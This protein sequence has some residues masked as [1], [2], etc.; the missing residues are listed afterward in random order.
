M[1]Q[2]SV[3]SV[4]ADDRKRAMQN[5]GASDKARMDQFFTSL[6]E[7]E[8]QMAAG[9]SSVRKSWPRSRSRSPGEMA[10]NY[11]LAQLRH[12]TPIMARLARWRWR[13]T[14]PGYSISAFPNPA[15]TCSC[16]AIR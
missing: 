6:R 3:L 11:A 5:L 13:P 1:L 14:R 9:A 2:Q 10:A 4:V 15:R 8:Q 12:V 7:T 16:L